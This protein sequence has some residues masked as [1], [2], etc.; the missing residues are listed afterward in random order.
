M[1][2]H[3]SAYTYIYTYKYIHFC[4]TSFLKQYKTIDKRKTKQINQLRFLI[5]NRRR[6]ANIQI[7]TRSQVVWLSEKNNYKSSWQTRLRGKGD[8]SHKSFWSEK[9]KHTTFPREIKLFLEPNLDR[10]FPCKEGAGTTRWYNNGQY[11]YNFR[12]NADEFQATLKT[13]TL[14]IKR[15]IR[16]T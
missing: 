15:K 6:K 13:I 9:R 16:F 14:L 12:V 2:V 3:L 5:V 4:F 10:K 7:I 1:Y 11:L 8:K